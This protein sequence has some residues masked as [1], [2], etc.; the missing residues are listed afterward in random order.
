M[1]LNQYRLVKKKRIVSLRNQRVSL[2][3][4]LQLFLLQKD[5]YL[6][7]EYREFDIIYFD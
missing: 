3:Q 4:I 7:L 1:T 6:I 2:K 5:G